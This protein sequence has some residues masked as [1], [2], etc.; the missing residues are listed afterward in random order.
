MRK[1]AFFVLAALATLVSCNR[2]KPYTIS[3]SFD[4]PDSLNFGDTVIAREPLDGMY[5]YMLNLDGEPIDSVMVENETFTFTG[6]VSAKDPYF[7][8]IA[9]DYS[10]GIIAIEPGEYGMTIGEEVLAFGSPTNDAINDIDARLTDIEQSVYEKLVVAMEQS[11]NEPSDSLLMPLYLEFNEKYA[12]LLDSISDANRKTLIGVYVAN[13]KTSEAA[14]EEEL[15]QMLEG[16]DDYVKE[17]PLMDA[18]RQYL[19]GI[20]SRFDYQSLIDE[21]TEE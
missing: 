13:I 11:G 19:R 17:S 20:N 2:E 14:S 8:Y 16:Y 5:V 7:A 21:D 15:E 12:S 6:K 10:Y 18:R 3:G 4:I 1:L 9:C